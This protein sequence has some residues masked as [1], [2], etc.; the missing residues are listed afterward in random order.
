M[1]ST[2]KIAITRFV[3][4][5]SKHQVDITHYSSSSIS[6]FIIQ[7]ELKYANKKLLIR[8]TQKITIFSHDFT[9]ST[10][11]FYTNIINFLIVYLYAPIE[12]K[13]RLASMTLKHHV[14]RQLFNIIQASRQPSNTQMVLRNV[15][16]GMIED[17]RLFNILLCILF[18]IFK[19]F[20]FT[21][22]LWMIDI[23]L[24]CYER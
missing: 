16:K 19:D 11:M 8:N 22:I 18:K 13:L 7:Y 24:H 14:I 1:Y 3:W 20:V 10:I 23:C 9:C 21:I 2:I 15:S 17:L 5:V 6:L 12:V 4:N